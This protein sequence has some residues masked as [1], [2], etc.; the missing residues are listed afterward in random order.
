MLPSPIMNIV[1]PLHWVSYADHGE[2]HEGDDSWGVA[3]EV[4]R[5]AAVAA[6]PCERAFDDP[7]F[8]RPRSDGD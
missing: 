8:G 4:A 1:A 7:A 5:Q 3:L 2:A 6:D